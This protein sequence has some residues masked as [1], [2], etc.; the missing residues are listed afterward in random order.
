MHNM[1][2]LTGRQ[3]PSLAAGC[4]LKAGNSYC[5]EQNGG[6]PP[7]GGSTTSRTTTASPATSTGNGLATP[8]PIQDGM[9]KGC[10]KF[11]LVVQGD[12]CTSIGSKYGVSMA[13]LFAWNPAIGS[14]CNNL[15][16]ETHLCVGVVG[17]ATATAT[18]TTLTTARTT[19]TTTRTAGNG[20]T[21]PT[22]TQE[23][24]ASNCDRFHLVVSA[25]RCNSIAS[26]YG[27]S[28]ADFYRWNPA[29][30]DRCLSLWV[31]T[32]VCVRTIGFV[33]SPTGPVSGFKLLLLFVRHASRGEQAC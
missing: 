19:A 18:A 11:H 24:M 14:N 21:T 2:L 7:A 20:I 1:N 13:Q 8:T 31:D 5:V 3:N 26:T 17:G 25:D 9:V 29:V 6:K 4:S 15:W 27:V 30:G 33:P 22:P 28:L 10:S 16:L 12:G 32:F 23:G